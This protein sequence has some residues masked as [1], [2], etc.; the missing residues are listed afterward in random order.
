[1]QERVTFDSSG[2]KLSGILHIP[3]D[4][5]KTKRPAFLVLHGFGSNKQSRAMSAPTEMLTSWGYAVL[6]FDMRGCGESEGERGRLLCLEQVED[7]KNALTYLASRPEI[8]AARIGCIGH[9]FGA[10]VAV[11]TGGVDQRVAAVI[12][13]GGWGDGVSKFRAQHASPEA[14]DRPGKFSNRSDL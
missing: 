4:G 10:A 14:W 1:M 13:S 6:R 2:L 11:Y 3:D 8:D 12:S 9:S 7:T 5:K